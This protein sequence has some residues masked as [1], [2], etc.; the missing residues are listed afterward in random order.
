MAT[1]VRIAE[2]ALSRI[3]V[4]R[5][6][7]GDVDGT[8]ANCTDTSPAKELAQEWFS[9]V[10]QRALVEAPWTFARKYARLTVVEED[11]VG[12]VQPWASHYQRAYGYPAD[13]LRARRFARDPHS[14][15]WAADTEPSHWPWRDLLWAFIV[16]VHD[17]ETVILSNVAA[18]DAD[19]EYTEDVTDTAR[20]PAMF[21]SA[22]A[23][24]LGSE[25]VLPLAVDLQKA[26]LCHQ[27][28][29]AES[30]K[31]AAHMLNEE[32][33]PPPADEEWIRSRGGL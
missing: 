20:F 21:T 24:L 31:A 10:R 1:E 26:Q 17:D 23:W 28:Y 16:R 13:C 9:D 11:L 14:R 18:T 5:R 30:W 12:T 6:F 15:F 8:L 29:R 3:G 32:L 25:M 19:L 7:T 27:M 2:M 22:F 4:A 33:P